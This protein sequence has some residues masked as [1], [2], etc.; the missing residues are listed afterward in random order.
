MRAFDIA[1][2]AVGA[3]IV[4]LADRPSLRAEVV[5]ALRASLVAGRMRPGVV[6][7][8]PMLAAEFGVSATPVREAM[9]DLAKEG[10][11]EAVRNRGFRVTEPSERL[12]DEITQLRALIEVPTVTLLAA[13]ADHDE[14]EALRPVALQ[15][16]MSA[17]EGNLLGYL[18]SDRRFHL[19]LLALAGNSELVELV[20]HLR[21]RTR[22]YGLEQLMEQGKLVASA[23][24]H[25]ELLDALVARDTD[26]ARTVMARHIGHIRG[27]WAA[28]LDPADAAANQSA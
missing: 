5:E 23:E 15:I 18:E 13:E 7:S 4:Q 12:L 6:Y 3:A 26:R 28:R 2:D 24:E 17:R 22:L 20:R 16:I 21:D 9:L 11:V 19:E 1:D 27:M 8:V 25:I 10:L 14:L